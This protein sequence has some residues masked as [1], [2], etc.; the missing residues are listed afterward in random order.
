MNTIIKSENIRG[1]I[2]NNIIK[3]NVICKLAVAALCSTLVLTGCAGQSKSNVSKISIVGSTS[4]QPLAEKLA[5]KYNESQPQV[6]IEIQGV[7]STAG[8]KA[9]NDGTCDIGT[10][11]REL[12]TEEKAWNLTET[13]IALDGIAVIASSNNKV[14]DLTKD[15]IVKI[16]KGEIKNWS[17]VGGD[18]KEIIVV[19]R[20]AGSGT[21]GA[22]EELLKLEKKEG[23]KTISLVVA[24]ALVA[25]GNGSVMANVAGK[26]NAIGYMSI[27]MVDETKV[28][29]LKLDG[30]EATEEN[31]KL[32]KYS[33]SRPFLM[34]TKGEA[35]KESKEFLDF[36][37]GEEGQKVVS[38]D[39][40]S[41]K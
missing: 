21:R 25:E 27:G 13:T 17:E 12:K 6:N 15:Q 10:S 24:N 29:K 28:K 11:S 37:L 2:M 36:I 32:G 35:K 22:F 7:G 9:V 20:E 39:Y 31:V 19:S 14:G 4:V 18:N 5:E 3:R 34:L 26:D 8:I 23:D 30:V 41:V 1:E 40:I 16:F 33:I 38:E